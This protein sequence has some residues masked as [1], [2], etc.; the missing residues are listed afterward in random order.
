MPDMTH[1]NELNKGLRATWGV[2]AGSR[3]ETHQD[4]A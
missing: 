3:P 1:D 4:A 2:A